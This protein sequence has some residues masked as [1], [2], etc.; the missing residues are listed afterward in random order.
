MFKKKS[1][2][3][4]LMAVL[5]L[6]TSGCSSPALMAPG[7]GRAIG[8]NVGG[9]QDI[10]LARELIKQGEVPRPDVFQVEGLYAEHDL[11]VAEAP[12]GKTLHLALGLGIAPALPDEKTT[13][14]VQVGLGSGLSEA[15]L[16][17]PRLKLVVVAD[18]SGSMSEDNKI[19]ALHQALRQLVGKL[20]EGDELALIDFDDDVQLIR[21]LGPVT[22]RAALDRQ[23]D[24][25]D[26]DGGTDINLGLKKGY[27]LLQKAQA[28]PG[29]DRRLILLTDAVPTVGTTSPDSF[30]NLVKTNAE[31]GIGLTAFG[32]GL[33]FGAQLANVIGT[34][35][36][37]NYAFLAGPDDVKKVFDEDF[38][39]LMTPAAYD[40]ELKVEPADGFKLSAVY[41]VPNFTLT[42]NAV[43]TLKVKSLFFSKN[44]GAIMLRFDEATPGA[45]KQTAQPLVAKGTLSYVERDGKTPV[46]EELEAAATGD[47]PTDGKAY[48]A[49]T[50]VRKAIA[51]TNEFL[52]MR[53]AARLYHI[54]NDKAK[55]RALLEKAKAEL[56]ATRAA[57]KDESLKPEVELITQLTT[58]MK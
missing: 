21:G 19:A 23:I 27:E 39:F 49:P 37:G 41:G 58:N 25:M 57:L 7:A 29:T 54:G 48:Y 47:R 20:K 5:A 18:T 46:T 1:S 22:D 52:A 13:H 50:A 16:K 32:I 30:E 35:R 51:L 8:A 28:E 11:P 17:R 56:E 4:I 36:G 44:R 2:I 33:D 26:A 15:D 31:A 34:Q 45:A 40:V 9:A 55:A 12:K 24:Q 14:W 3:W 42:E 43:Y 53:E 6:A 10:K 38:D